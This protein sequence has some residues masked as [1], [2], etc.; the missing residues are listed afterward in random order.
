MKT[1]ALKDLTV[2]ISRNALVICQVGIPKETDVSK[3]LS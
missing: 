2:T 1:F 3:S